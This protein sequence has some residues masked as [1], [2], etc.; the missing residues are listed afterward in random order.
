MCRKALF[1]L[2]MINDLIHVDGDVGKD[3]F[4]EQAESRNIIGN[5]ER[6]IKYSRKKTYLFIML[7]LDLVQI[8]KSGLL[9]QSYFGR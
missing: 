8:L 7:F 2:D 1:I 5:I 6:V 3:G 9:K 4:Y